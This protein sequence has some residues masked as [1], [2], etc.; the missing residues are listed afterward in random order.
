MENA[1]E[2]IGQTLHNIE[3]L[4]QYIHSGDIERD[5]NEGC[6]HDRH[7]LLE[8]LESIMDFS[9]VCDETATKLIFK[10]KLEVLTSANK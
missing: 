2:L 4:K 6:E 10:G 1:S 7:Y 8:F 5:F 9:D 3:L